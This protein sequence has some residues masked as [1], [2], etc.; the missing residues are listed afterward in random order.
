MSKKFDN[1]FSALMLFA[2]VAVVL[3][4]W[5]CLSHSIARAKDDAVLSPPMAPVRLEAPDPEP[6]PTTAPDMERLESP[7]IYDQTIPLSAELQAALC[8]ACD[9]NDVPVALVLGVIHV[10]SLFQVDADNGQCYGLM[11]LNRKYFPDKLSPSDNLR[12]GI[13]YLGRLMKQYGDTA[14]ALTA[15]N[16]GHDTGRRAYANAVLD[17]AEWWEAEL[18]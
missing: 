1:L 9:E 16:A 7:Y 15:Y 14:A 8:E 11:Q 12:V 13:E 4:G 2:A 3:S 17:A 6:T 18:E 5:Y 10:E